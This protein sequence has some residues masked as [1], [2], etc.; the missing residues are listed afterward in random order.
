MKSPKLIITL[1]AFFVYTVSYSQEN[2]FIRGTVYEDASGEPM[3]TVKV[4]I[5][6]VTKGITDLDG[7]FS[8]SLAPGTYELSISFVSFATIVIP[9]ITVTSGKAEVL[10]NLRL[11]Q[12]DEQL[13]TVVV[14]KERVTNTENSI[15]TMK[16]D[17]T[18]LMDGI[19]SA[20]FRKMGDSNAAV[21]MSRV[22][23][24]SLAGG[25]Y[26]YVRGLGD[27]YNKTLLGGVDV[28][29]LDPDRNTIQMD[30]FPTS[31]LD[32]I[33]VNK[34]FVAELPAD[35]TGGVIN[36]NL[37]SFP[38]ERQRGFSVSLGYNP[39]F[40]F[41]SNYLTYEG[42]KTDWLGF[43][44]GTRNIPAQ[45]RIPQ[46]VDALGG[47]KDAE[48]YQEIL[49][50]FNPNLAAYE[51][52]S[53]MDF[54]L[55]TSWGNQ[56]KKND[57]VTI[58]YNAILS[59][60]NKTE[61]YNEAVYGRYGLSS[62]ADVTEMELRELQTG[63]F[64]QNSVLVSGMAGFAVKTQS[65]KYT[66]NLLHL[67]NGQSTAGIYD[68]YNA[69]QGSVFEGFQHNLEYNQ[70]SL[71]NALITGKHRLD[72][73][74]WEIEWKISP[75][76]SLLKDPDIRFTRY[77]VRN[78]S[79]LYIGT[80]SG[81]PE[82]I[83]RELQEYNLANVLH[84]TK[85]FEFMDEKAKWKFGGAYTYKQ[86][87]F[88]VRSFALNVRNIPLTGDPNEL[89]WDENIWPYN[90]DPNSGTTYEVSFIP[91]NPNK[92]SSNV[93]YGAAYTS[94]EVSPTKK[95][96][97]IL[98][99]RAENYVQRYTGQDQL[100]TNVLA[101]EKVLDDLGIFPSVNFVY[102]MNEK[103]NLRF[104]YGKTIARPSFK[105]LSYAEIF[106]PLTG[107]TFIGGLFRDANENAGIVYWDGNLQVTD[108]HNLDLRYEVFNKPGQTVSISAFYKKFFNPI[109][110]VQYATQVGA[111]QPRNVG[112][113]EVYGGEFEL[114]QGLEFMGDKMKN[115]YFNTN[116][117]YTYS[118]IKLSP[119]EL[120]SR[121]DNARSGQVIGEYRD[122]AGQAPYLINGGFAYQG[123]APE[124]DQAPRFFNNFEAGIYYNMQ[125]PTLQFVGIV[126]R[127]DIYSV[128]FHSLNFNATKSF[129]PDNNY[130]LG[131]KV[132]NLLN[133]KKEQVFR[134]YNTQDQF[135]QSL[136]P[137]TSAR[138]K[139]S[140]KF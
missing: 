130:S 136:A 140:M 91:N 38:E 26:V 76:L 135:F 51:T 72:S 139:F 27:R 102:K 83:W 129:G 134:S 64:G 47:G 124:K 79:L 28:P 16:R 49:G 123:R 42:G 65:S 137:G 138:L 69:D 77:E 113:G 1:L 96:K 89:F 68:Y 13:K 58:G 66:L 59:Y 45:S 111:F 44:D 84:F 52:M 108:I 21:A 101:N 104:S 43:D 30:I 29:G 125:G 112:D 17:G 37:K 40:H 18:N 22:P 107:R 132:S 81:F 133:D 55:S 6:G 20:N 48:R 7:K 131:I 24:V 100:G 60:S 3:P 127:P 117:T 63:S 75:T 10:D 32:N 34:S 57:K 86:R 106:D 88:N 15:L 71:T 56:F 87:D 73:S 53:L 85:E 105:E 5:D 116:I 61:F 90:G 70:R 115:F 11:G 50:N 120:Q 46:Y 36:V 67:Q 78:D 23:G 9:D 80:E 103:Q 82:R 4:K 19:S 35:F 94:I 41:Q 33:V 12:S 121:Q 14:T 93:N 98:G 128:P 54:G 74:K 25:K 2:G 39:Y 122:M 92:F 95:L 110:I 118:R 99:V 126:D 114:R 97:A 62:D 109:E 31:L 8:I 119:T